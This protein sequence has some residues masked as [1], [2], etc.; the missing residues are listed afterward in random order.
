[1]VSWFRLLRNLSRKEKSSGLMLKVKVHPLVTEWN[2]WRDVQERGLVA[3]TI[4]M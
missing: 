4:L 1:M 2:A 3:Y